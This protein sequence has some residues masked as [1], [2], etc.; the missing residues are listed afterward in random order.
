MRLVIGSK[1]PS[2][3]IDPKPRTIEQWWNGLEWQDHVPQA[4]MM[5]FNGCNS[6]SLT[7]ELMCNVDVLG[8]RLTDL[9]GVEWLYK[10][11]AHA[12]EKMRKGFETEYQ[13]ILEV[14][15]SW[16]LY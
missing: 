2:W 13:N 11:P 5:Y 15:S 6:D 16:T 4:E 1:V 9:F 10:I 8:W 3:W 7:Q 14:V 12:G